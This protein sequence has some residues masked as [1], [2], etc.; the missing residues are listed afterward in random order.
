MRGKLSAA[1]KHVACR[2]RAERSFYLSS[3]PEALARKLANCDSALESAYAK[4]E[5]A[6][7]Q[8][9]SHYGD[10]QNVKELNTAVATCLK[11]GSA[12]GSG[13]NCLA[14]TVAFTI[15]EGYFWVQPSPD[16]PACS[17][18]NFCG[19]LGTSQCEEVPRSGSDS[20]RDTLGDK[21][22]VDVSSTCLFAQTLTNGYLTNSTRSVGPCY[23]FMI[24]QGTV[25][26][27]SFADYDIPY[28]A[29]GCQ[30]LSTLEGIYNR[31]P[32]DP[33]NG[34]ANCLSAAIDIHLIDFAVDNSCA[35]QFIMLLCNNPA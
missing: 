7:P 17:S 25:P 19:P 9:C 29:Q 24:N 3:R 26:L 11:D 18:F 21:I 32:D 4:R 33:S 27:A 14:T 12:S 23:D 10:V 31:D 30:I 15:P 16:A 28:Y 20:C 2:V 1:A 22:P 34:P 6:I 13:V 8:E 35:N 5:A